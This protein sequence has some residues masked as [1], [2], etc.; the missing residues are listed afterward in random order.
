MPTPRWLALTLILSLS[1]PGGAQANIVVNGVFEATVSGWSN[2]WSSVNAIAD[3]G[4]RSAASGC[5]DPTC[6]DPSSP[7]QSF[8]THELP[9]VEGG[10]YSL[11]F[12]L[13]QVGGTQNALRAYWG[14]ALVF[15][16]A[17]VR[18]CAQ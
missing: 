4:S 12:F 11:H 1:L 10:V 14:G 13:N 7:A 17:D 3:S 2:N 5:Q 15:S 9:P 18:T 6:V 8:L 16:M